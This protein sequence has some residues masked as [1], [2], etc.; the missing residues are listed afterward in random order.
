M[1]KF[2]PVILTSY[3]EY[4]VLVNEDAAKSL[5]VIFKTQNFPN[6]GNRVKLE[7]FD[8]FKIIGKDYIIF[9]EMPMIYLVIDFDYGIKFETQR[10]YQGFRHDKYD[11]KE[12]EA[13]NDE[14]YL[15]RVNESCFNYNDIKDIYEIQTKL[16][17]ES[18]NL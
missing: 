14:E 10:I 16:L 8:S 13:E 5:Q 18:E 7:G 17:F 15:K 3:T 2:V 12:F 6:V 9:K 11:G 1:A 4:I